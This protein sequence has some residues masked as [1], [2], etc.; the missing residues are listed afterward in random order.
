MALSPLPPPPSLRV[1]LVSFLFRKKGI[2]DLQNLLCRSSQ[3]RSRTGDCCA[4][5]SEL[6]RLDDSAADQVRERYRATAES[7]TSTAE[8]GGFG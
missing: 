3:R 8:G 7:D 4:A 2:A 6:L 1:T 5:V